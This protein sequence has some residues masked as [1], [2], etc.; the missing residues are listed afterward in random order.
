M[1]PRTAGEFS[2][3]QF[4]YT[5]FSNLDYELILKIDIIRKYEVLY[6]INSFCM[7]AEPYGSE[8]SA[9][10]LLPVFESA[11]GPEAVSASGLR[12]REDPAIQ[13]RP[14]C[15]AGVCRGAGDRLDQANETLFGPE[16]SES[17]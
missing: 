13:A 3:L 16:R 11:R 7:I 5:T 14:E 12:A 8:V 2:S 4:Q 6:P 1:E 15:S 10:D 9:P 17:K